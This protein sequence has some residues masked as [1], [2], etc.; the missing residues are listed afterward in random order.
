MQTITFTHYGW[1]GICPILIADPDNATPTFR[2]RYNYTE[3]LFDFSDWMF[4][5][6]NDIMELINPDHEPG[7]PYTV[8]G[9][10]DIPVVEQVE[11]DDIQ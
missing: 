9:K 1:F 10:L 8:K 6:C 5:R 3:W 2:P 7:F 4:D 11:E